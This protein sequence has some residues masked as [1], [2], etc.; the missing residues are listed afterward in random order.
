MNEIVVSEDVT[1]IIPARANGNTKSR[2]TLFAR[3]L[4]GRKGKWWKP[5]LDVYRDYLLFVREL[6]PTSVS[7]HLS[8]I[9][10]RYAELL[11]DRDLLYTLAPDEWDFV[12]RKSFVDEMKSR[13]EN[14]IHP[15]ESTVEVTSEQDRSDAQSL[16]LTPTQVNELLHM[17]GTKDRFGLRDTAMIALM[18]CTGIREAELTALDVTDLRH[19]LNSIPALLVRKGKG[20]KQRLVPYGNLEWS[21]RFADAWMKSAGIVDSWVF[22][23]IYK[24]GETVGK[25][26][27]STRAVQKILS[28]YPIWHQGELRVVHPHDLRRSYARNL[29]DAGVDPV[30][31]QQNLGHRSLQVTLGYIGNIDADQRRPPAIYQM[32]LDIMRDL[33]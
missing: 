19:T 28:Q 30:R 5:E 23:R 24:G 1:P 25:D 4:N 9:R 12:A 16:R 17:P 33:P 2:L 22:R 6:E 26:E 8:T 10:A 15:D 13:I 32:P 7:A 14:A 21:L 29:Y 20:N 31:I 27:L 3:W 18:L 11:R